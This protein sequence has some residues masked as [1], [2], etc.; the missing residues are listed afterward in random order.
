MLSQILV[1]KRQKRGLSDFNDLMKSRGLEEVKKQ[2][3]E[4]IARELNLKKVMQNSKE[5][6]QEIKVKK[7][8]SISI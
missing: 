7:D 4:Q 6:K 2:L 8:I 3:K 1:K 5:Q